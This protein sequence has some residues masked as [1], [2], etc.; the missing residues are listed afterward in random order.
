MPREEKVKLAELVGDSLR[1]WQGSRQREAFQEVW[2]G[3][4]GIE[5][6][7]L[8]EYFRLFRYHRGPD[9]AEAVEIFQLCLKRN[10]DLSCGRS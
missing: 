9:E 4:M 3:T 5:T 8:E 10:E 7:A 1:A 2:A 6:A